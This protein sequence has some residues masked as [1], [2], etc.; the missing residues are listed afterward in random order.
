MFILWGGKYMISNKGQTR[1]R[2]LCPRCHNNLNFIIR[3]KIKWFTIYFVPLFP[4][5]FQK[6]IICPYCGR[7]IFV[8]KENYKEHLKN[9]KRLKIRNL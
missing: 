7:N 8:S 3:S 2:I 5:R 1:D 4:Y 9:K 6:E